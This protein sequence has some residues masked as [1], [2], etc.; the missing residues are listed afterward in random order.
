M[1][2]LASHAQVFVPPPRRT[3]PESTNTCILHCASQREVTQLSTGKTDVCTCLCCRNFFKKCRLN[4]WW[5]CLCVCVGLRALIGGAI[6]AC[7][8]CKYLAF[9]ARLP[10]GACFVCVHVLACACTHTRGGCA[11]FVLFAGSN[12]R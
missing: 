4:G 7:R 3:W 1:R 5:R 10:P 8:R 9:L 12:D 11:F 6:W 2:G